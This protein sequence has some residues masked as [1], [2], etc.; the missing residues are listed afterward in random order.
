[1]GARA[2]LRLACL[3]AAL[4]MAGC[5]GAMQVVEKVEHG[6]TAKDM[7]YYRSYM[8][9]GREPTFDERRRWEDRL[10]ERVAK[11]LRDHPDMEQSNRY[12]DFRF[13]RQVMIGA[14]RD[15]V[16]TLLDDP[17]EE[18]TDRA[19]ME[20]M[21]KQHWPGM[22]RRVKEAWVYPPGWVLYFDDD[23]VMQITRKIGKYEMQD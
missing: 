18:T 7:F 1:M 13:W 3:A 11:Y 9:N 20:S 5:L 17:D 8:A 19:L 21:A 15:E 14:T 10:D 23:A 22:Q 12:S 6:P 16:V 2:A 4:G